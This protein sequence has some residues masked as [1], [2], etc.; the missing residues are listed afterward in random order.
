MLRAKEVAGILGVSLRT[1]RTYVRDG[2]IPSSQA[3][4]RA[5]RLIPEPAIISLCGTARWLR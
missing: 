1:V 2:K 3:A 5:A 4:P